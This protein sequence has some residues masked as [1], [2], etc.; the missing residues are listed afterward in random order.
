MLKLLDHKSN[1][2]TKQLE[3]ERKKHKEQ[4]QQLAT[5]HNELVK[6]LKK[7][8]DA[9]TKRQKQPKTPAPETQA[10]SEPLAG[11]PIG[12]LT[13]SPAAAAPAPAV[14]AKKK[15]KSKKASTLN[16][17]SLTVRL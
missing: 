9:E 6:V 17:Q 14:A 5:A 12:A 15:G 10:G 4:L 16:E 1:V 8:Q 11:G 13:S 2:L 7:N 3:E